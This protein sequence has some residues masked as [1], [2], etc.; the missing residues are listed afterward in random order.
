MAV[1]ITRWQIVPAGCDSL[2]PARV[3]WRVPINGSRPSTSRALRAPYHRAAE[4]APPAVRPSANADS[5]ASSRSRRGA[6][7]VGQ[8]CRRGCQSGP[9]RIAGSGSNREATGDHQRAIDPI[10]SG[11]GS[12][13]PVH[14]SSCQSI[15]TLTGI[16][17]NDTPIYRSSRS[18]LRFR[19]TRQRAGRAG[20]RARISST[21]SRLR[22]PST[23]CAPLFA[24]TACACWKTNSSRIV[25][26]GSRFA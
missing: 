3:T 11:R 26:P 8:A 22:I 2:G 21:R 13:Y 15:Q 1:S 5:A 14:P 7:H 10:G 18:A 20:A 16:P 17:A 9:P 24:G 19:P 6:R 23:S 4:G 12:R 25:A